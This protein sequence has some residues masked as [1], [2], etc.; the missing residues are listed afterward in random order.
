[1]P[2]SQAEIDHLAGEGVIVKTWYADPEN[3]GQATVYTTLPSEE[4]LELWEDA[5]FTNGGPLVKIELVWAPEEA[6][7]LATN[8]DEEEAKHTD[9]AG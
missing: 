3:K 5:A 7:K 8:S 1:M 9:K 4:E 2:I 6:R